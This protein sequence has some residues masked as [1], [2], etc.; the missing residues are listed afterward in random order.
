MKVPKYGLAMQDNQL[1]QSLHSMSKH[2]KYKCI[3]ATCTY[4][5]VFDSVM[6]YH[7]QAGKNLHE[8]DTFNVFVID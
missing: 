8:E 6:F 3:F 4:G 2:I 5:T 1:H 7:V